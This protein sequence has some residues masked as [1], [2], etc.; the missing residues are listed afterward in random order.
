M[1]VLNGIQTQTGHCK[2]LIN[3]LETMKGLVDVVRLS[4]ETETLDWLAKFDKQQDTP[5]R[6][7]L[8]HRECNGYWLNLAG[9]ELV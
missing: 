1:F 3:Q 6:Y 9:M 8:P 7:A 4:P 2:N 5:E